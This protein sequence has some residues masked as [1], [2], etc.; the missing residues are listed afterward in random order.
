MKNLYSYEDIPT[1][2]FLYINSFQRKERKS[3]SYTN[4]LSCKQK[5][6]IPAGN[7]KNKF[8]VLNGF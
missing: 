4:I 7:P 1:K 2:L 3:V 6:L 8:Y 5:R